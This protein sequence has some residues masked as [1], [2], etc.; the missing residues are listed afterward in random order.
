[1]NDNQKKTNNI[2]DDSSSRVEE[3]LCELN[4]C[5]EDER[6]S[7]NLIIQIISTAGTIL[8][9][10]I[11]TSIF[12]KDIDSKILS[13]MSFFSDCIFITAFGY[14]TSLGI[15]NVLR[16]HYIQEL[17][18]E[19]SKLN[20]DSCDDSEVLHWMSYSSP[21]ITR[22]PKHLKSL[23]SVIHFFCYCGATVFAIIFSLF[24]TLF[25][26]VRINHHIWID[27]A[28]IVSVFIFTIILI[29]SLLLSL[30]NAQKMHAYAMKHSK[31]KKELRIHQ[32]ILIDATTKKLDTTSENTF[33][34]NLYCFKNILRVVGYFL[35]PK[36][37]DFQ[38]QLLVIIGSIT[39][40]FFLNGKITIQNIYNQIYSV[41]FTVF[42][43]DFLAYQARYQWNDVRGLKEDIE[44]QRKDRLPAEILG[45]KLAVII[46]ISLVFIK[47]FL[48][49]II[50]RNFG[51]EMRIPL[52]TCV[53]A[54]II[55]SLIYESI[56]SH[57][58]KIHEDQNKYKMLYSIEV[59][60]AVSLGYPIRFLVGVWAIYPEL[61]N[62][63][64]KIS[65]ILIPHYYIIILLFAYAF[66]GAFVAILPW[67]HEAIVQAKT[68]R[69]KKIH[70]Q[71][72]FDIIEERYYKA[73][74]H[75][76]LFPLREEG[77]LFDIWNCLYLLSMLLLSF[78]CFKFL[79]SFY[80]F[81]LELIFLIIII[82]ICLASQKK[83]IFYFVLA[84]NFCIMKIIGSLV[85]ISV[86]P[87]YIY[88]CFHQIFFTAI[89]FFLRYL[90]DPDFNF[91]IILKTALTKLIIWIIGKETWEYINF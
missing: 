50:I 29:I 77:N 55:L 69:I 35:Y 40:I 82:K 53:F 34:L 66:F 5:R 27:K 33:V 62:S 86:Y 37:K 87:F 6:N 58:K 22:N 24:M 3:I 74:E 56:R 59:F 44:A 91:V 52:K 13:I 90:F 60:F 63:N 43:F 19:L 64:I 88:I 18:D 81:I 42:V 54:V 72:L 45:K 85:F 76:N 1:M 10:I 25:Q 30:F 73:L 84:I 21:I 15:K 31:T 11:G 61:W 78:M 12:Q 16:Y 75:N 26:Y 79:F 67:T 14:I 41:L 83:I 89:Y 80:G 23:Y 48:S 20:I 17:E 8:G 68:K 9:I 38:K 71:Y 39:G 70:Y 28:G 49:F 7:E 47:Y 36:A 51:G 65:N 32:K 2:K 57:K 4:E 46:S